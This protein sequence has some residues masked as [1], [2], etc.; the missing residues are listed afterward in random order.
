[1]DHS[2]RDET[3]KRSRAHQTS[4]NSKGPQEAAL[5]CT[6]QMGQV[7]K[8]PKMNSKRDLYKIDPS[9]DEKRNRRLLSIPSA[10]PCRASASLLRPGLISAPE[11]T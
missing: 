4:K 2:Q 7:G 9:L 11:T 8:C 6:S 5:S 1:M 3:M 10:M